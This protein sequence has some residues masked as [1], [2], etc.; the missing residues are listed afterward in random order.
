MLAALP[1]SL[2]P[3]SASASHSVALLPRGPWSGTW[4]VVGLP[5]CG[6]LSLPPGDAAS[7]AGSLCAA[8]VLLRGVSGG[9]V[10]VTRRVKAVRAEGCVDLRLSL[11]HGSVASVEL[12]RCERV[13]LS[14]GG[15][16][17]AVRLDDCRDVALAL[18]SAAATGHGG[19]GPA[20]A[21]GFHVLSTG[22]HHVRVAFPDGGGGGAREA[23]LPEMVRSVLAA[24]ATELSHSIV[25]AASPWG[26][27]DEAR[28]SFG[29]HRGQG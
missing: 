12:L 23:A 3:P 21:A 8:D 22:C 15:A 7:A 18:S 2:A 19:D 9:S 10:T 5:F 20:G 6:S 14:L 4:E 16:V 28:P 24:G 29:A 27:A 17:S 25:S 13:T 11:P 1:P 26:A